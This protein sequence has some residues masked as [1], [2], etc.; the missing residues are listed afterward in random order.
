MGCKGENRTSTNQETM[1]IEFNPPKEIVYKDS[2]A[3]YKYFQEIE[4]KEK[5]LTLPQVKRY[6]W[7]YILHKCPFFKLTKENK[8]LLKDLSEYVVGE[9]ELN[10]EKG[11]YLYGA[12]G[13]GKSLIMEPFMNLLKAKQKTT[14]RL[15]DEYNETENFKEYGTGD[16]YFDD[17]GAEKLPKFFKAGSEP[18][19]TEVLQERY[20]KTHQGFEKGRTF[21]SSNLGPKN[22]SEMYGARV[23]SRMKQMFNIIELPGIDYR[24]T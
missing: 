16:W 14:I 20:S 13:V 23:A 5:P 18:L 15:V 22:F 19:M 7:N 10:P 11:I 2:K 3:I 8:K 24:N 6:A 9:G 4:N 17:L 21:V 12:Y 1:G